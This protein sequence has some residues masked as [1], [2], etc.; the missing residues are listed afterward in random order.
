MSMLN[1][2]K[3]SMKRGD[4]VIRI[5]GEGGQGVV[6]VGELLDK[7]VAQ[8]GLHVLT[9]STFTPEIKGGDVM[10]QLTASPVP[11][12]SQGDRLDILVAL[13]DRGYRAN[14]GNLVPGSVLIYDHEDT[15]PE[16]LD[17]VILYSIPMSDI[18]RSLGSPLLKNMVA[19]GAVAQLFS[20][21]MNGL[22]EQIRKRFSKKDPFVL[23]TNLGAFEAGFTYAGEQIQKQDL[24]YLITPGEKRDDLLLMN[25]NEA[26]GLGALI[27]GCRFYAY[28]P[29]TPATTIGDWLTSRLP[30]VGGAIIQAEDPIESASLA[31][32]VSY[33]GTK[34]MI[35]TS[36][37]G[38]DLMQECIGYAGMAEIP[39]V[40][41]DVQRVGPGNGI[42]TQ[43]EQS[44][45]L[46]AAFGSHG[47][48]PK[49]VLAATDVRDCLDLT[50]EAFNLAEH[51]QVPV[52]LLSD[53]SLSRR[54]QTI[55]RPRLPEI[56][57]IP[58]TRYDPA[59]SSYAR[60]QV[61]RDGI[62]PMSLPGQSG[63]EYIATSLEHAETCSLG[64]GPQ[65]HTIMT[66]KRFRKLDALEE[67]FLPLEREGPARAEVGIISWGATQGAVREAVQRFRQIGADVAA[68]YPKLLWPL[69]VKALETFAA[70]VNKVVVV[71]ANK[72]GQLAGMIRA[73]TR[74]EP[75]RIQTYNGVPITAW[76]IFGKEGLL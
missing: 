76:D 67:D 28:Y 29:I 49:I 22:Q 48:L 31:I 2:M 54:R 18:S 47:D 9:E 73:C 46:A 20:I 27:A 58:R 34:A 25:G 57:I 68:L 14:K 59:P 6:T 33:A 11:I 75:H 16:G 60:Y 35:G 36:G 37:P 61:T 44:D 40:I 50:I 41:V 3:A 62:S 64:D 15:R 74:L 70:S 21:P 4:P 17:G 5:A 26:I 51:Y 23:R 56:R 1:F 30:E 39:I 8:I 71:E 32:G 19:L 24:Y 38:L 45:L 66:D 7:A 12:P 43:C 42:A 72:Q 65:G 53:A 63:G 13:N 55:P 52:I 69:P 10:F